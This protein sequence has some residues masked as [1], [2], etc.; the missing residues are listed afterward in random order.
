MQMSVIMKKRRRSEWMETSGARKCRMLQEEVRICSNT[1]SIFN[2]LISRISTIRR[3]R[4]SHSTGLEPSISRVNFRVSRA[5]PST[6]PTSL[7]EQRESRDSTT[8]SSMST[9]HQQEEK[10]KDSSLKQLSTR[11]QSRLLRTKNEWLI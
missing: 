9:N 1:N 3:R 2:H 10:D 6:S 11:N 8:T 7:K 5:S 4:D